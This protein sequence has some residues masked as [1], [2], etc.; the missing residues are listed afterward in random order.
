[1]VS[2]T[3]IDRNR[4]VPEL[5]NVFHL[6]PNGGNKGLHQLF[7]SISFKEPFYDVDEL[8]FG[9]ESRIVNLH[10]QVISLNR[11]SAIL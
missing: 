5:T 11:T 4:G 2:D 7:R 10:I 9:Q 6:I 1:M 8:I 3:C